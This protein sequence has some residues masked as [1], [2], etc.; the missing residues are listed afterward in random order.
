VQSSEEIDMGSET[1]GFL[2]CDIDVMG[3]HTGLDTGE[4]FVRAGHFEDRTRRGTYC[5]RQAFIV[6][7]CEREKHD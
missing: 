7:A 2:D 6:F 3:P 4:A 1:G 5:C